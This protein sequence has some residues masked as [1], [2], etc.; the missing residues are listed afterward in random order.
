MPLWPY[1]FGWR[2][3]WL[4]ATLALTSLFAA[5]AV[6]SRFTSRSWWFG[7]GRQLLFGV[8][9]AA[10]AFGVGRLIGQSVG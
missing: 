8:L 2:A 9:S 10:V 5:G 1:L 3:L 6:S 7:G 4:S